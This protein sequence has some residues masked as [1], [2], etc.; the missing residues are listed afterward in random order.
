M[1]LLASCFVVSFFFAKLLFAG[2]RLAE[3]VVFMTV[4]AGRSKMHAR[5]AG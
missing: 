2:V 5:L 4:L 1:H 3:L